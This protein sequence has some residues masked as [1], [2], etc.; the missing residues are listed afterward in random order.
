VLLRSRRRLHTRPSARAGAGRAV[1]CVLGGGEVN[2]RYR[3]HGPRLSAA[4]ALRF[5]TRTPTAQHPQ[6]GSLSVSSSTAGASSGGTLNR[7]SSKAQVIA[8]VEA[9]GEALRDADVDLRAD[10]DVVRAAALQLASAL[11][12][13]SGSLRADRELVHEVAA[14]DGRALEH[15]SADLQAD[16]DLVMTA[17]SQTGSALRHAARALKSDR[18]VVVAAVSVCCSLPSPTHCPTQG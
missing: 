13:A 14:R 8:V 15:A 17:V 1:L 18:D 12:Y 6:M 5:A 9:D 16:K 4:M 11:A 3:P 10:K 7:F 2:L